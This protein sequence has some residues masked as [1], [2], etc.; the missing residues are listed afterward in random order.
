M[1]TADQYLKTIFLVEQLHDGPAATGEL[2]DRLG[3]SPAS[4]NEM[5]GKLEERGLV[6]H[7][8]YKGASVTD[9]GEA[10]AREALRR[11]ASSS[12][13]SRTS[14]T[15]MTSGRRPASSS[16]SSTRRSP[17]AST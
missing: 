8:K 16:R 13:S 15:S 7:E 9:D 14:L 11:T 2:A 12:A 6:T 1:N 17:T 5:I 4:V 3:V 10:L